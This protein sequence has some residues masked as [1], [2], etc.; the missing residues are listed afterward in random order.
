MHIHIGII[1][2]ILHHI[3]YTFDLQCSMEYGSD[4][5]EGSNKANMNALES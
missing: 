1:S 5:W 4:I 3:M 2:M